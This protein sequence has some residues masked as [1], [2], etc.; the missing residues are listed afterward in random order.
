MYEIRLLSLG[1]ALKAIVRNYQPLMMLLDEEA[2]SGDPTSIGL[3]LQLS[4]YK[5][6]A[7]LHLT[8][9]VLHIMNNLGRIFQ[10]TDLSFMTIKK[11]VCNMHMSIR[12][13]ICLNIVLVLQNAPRPEGSVCG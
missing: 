1:D 2:S 9:D 3:H 13:F 12:M 11:K 5:V 6:V 10:Y 7:L 8:A 4:S